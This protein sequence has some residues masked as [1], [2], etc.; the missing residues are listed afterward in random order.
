MVQ[1]SKSQSLPWV[2]VTTVAVVVI[3]VAWMG[4][5]W[6]PRDPKTQGRT[7][8][9]RELAPRH[10]ALIGADTPV[11]I[12]LLHMLGH[13]PLVSD[14]VVITSTQLITRRPQFWPQKAIQSLVDL[15]DE[16]NVSEALRGISTV[17]WVGGG[18]STLVTRAA[19]RSGVK[20]VSVMTSSVWGSVKSE[21]VRRTERILREAGVARVSVFRPRS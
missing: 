1:L 6:A 17:Y 12:E 5:D 11:G 9:T 16:R 2:V 3:L 13:S 8:I 19:A 18:N 14:I 10:V 15:S 7:S 20:H 21:N 4:A